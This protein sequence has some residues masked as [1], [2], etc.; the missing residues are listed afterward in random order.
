MARQFKLTSSRTSI[1]HLPILT[2]FLFI[3][4]NI[5]PGV[6]I[7][8]CTERKRDSSQS[9]TRHHT[10]FL[11]PSRGSPPPPMVHML[12]LRSPGSQSRIISSFR[13]VP[14]VVTITL[15]PKCLLISMQIW[16]VWRASS[17]VGTMTRAVTNNTEQCNRKDT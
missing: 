10:Q 11:S 8:T 4:S 9:N 5:L 12:M 16:L 6:A 1:P 2:R 3:R 7:I 13:F 15:S 14:P 17:R